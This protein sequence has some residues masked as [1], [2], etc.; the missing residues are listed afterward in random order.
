[1][2]VI[3]LDIVFFM[4]CS[5]RKWRNPVA[6]AEV[7]GAA[8]VLGIAGPPFDGTHGNGDLDA[9]EGGLGAVLGEGGDRLAGEGHFLGHR[10]LH[11]R[12]PFES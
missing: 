9:T 8:D 12:S 2:R 1:V 7:S 10:L 11:E 4:K 6:R 5:F 3:F